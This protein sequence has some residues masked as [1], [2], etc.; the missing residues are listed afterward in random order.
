MPCHTGTAR[1]AHIRKG[2]AVVGFDGATCN[3]TEGLAY[4]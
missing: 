4:S 1:S 2:G 3:G